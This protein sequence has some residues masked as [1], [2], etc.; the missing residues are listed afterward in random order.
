MSFIPPGNFKAGI[1][2][3]LA[4]SAVYPF[5]F[6]MAIA[7]LIPKRGCRSSPH[8]FTLGSYVGDDEWGSLDDLLKG[9][10]EAWWRNRMDL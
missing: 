10:S 7:S 3:A 9:R 8:A 4:K 2:S 6:G 1:K 5:E